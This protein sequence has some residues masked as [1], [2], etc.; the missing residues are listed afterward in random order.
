MARQEKGSNNHARTR[1]LR[2]REYRI[3]S[4]PEP[5]QGHG[6]QA[7]FQGGGREPSRRLG[8]PEC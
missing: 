5:A 2:A 1:T 4:Y 6:V 7:G 3:Q 8:N